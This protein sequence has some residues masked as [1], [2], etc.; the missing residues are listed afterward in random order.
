MLVSH[1]PFCDSTPFGTYEKILAAYVHFSPQVDP[2]ARDLISSLLTVDVSK[3]IG[4]FRGG[5]NDVMEHAWFEGVG[6]QALLNR[7]LP[8]PFRPHQFHRS[9]SSNFDIYGHYDVSNMP[10]MHVGIPAD[11]PA[12]DSDP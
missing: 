9:D 10:V 7:R 12:L 11:Q 8:A 6:W 1:P 5:A 3:R 4:K 2:I